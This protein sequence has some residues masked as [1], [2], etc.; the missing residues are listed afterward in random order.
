MR[1]IDERGTVQGHVT[2]G[3][4]RVADAFAANFRDR[5]E[6]GAACAVSLDGQ[7]VVDI[8]GGVADTQTKAPW[9]EGTAVLV[10]SI[11]KGL[12]ASAVAVL[13]A[14]GLL[15]LDA[16][17]SSYWPEF[18]QAGKAEVTAADVLA[19]RSGV[20]TIDQRLTLSDL[21]DAGLLV[22]LVASQR[23]CGR[24]A[25]VRATTI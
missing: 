9:T 23:P 16:S 11:A 5:G 1:S 12:T 22:D 8:W 10:F 4:G 14:R 19:H 20:S 15:D 21:S 2:D 17:I 7:L 18:G 3:W 6:L 24:L 13:A 25:P